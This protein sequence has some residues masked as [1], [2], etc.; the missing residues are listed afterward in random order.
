ME[1]VRDL[2]EVPALPALAVIVN[3]GTPWVTSLAL[4]SVLR[5][6]GYPVLL[7]DCASRDG[8]RA[9][10]RTLALAHDWRFYWLEWPLRRHGATLDALFGQAR[11]ESV[12]L[13]DSD[14]ELL[15]GRAVRAMADALRDEPDAY[16]AGFLQHAQWLGAE[17]GWPPGVGWYAER[18]WIPLVHLATLP[19]RAALAA[20]ASFAQCR[21]FHAWRGHPM[22]GRVLGWRYRLPRATGRR[23]AADAG[24]DDIA[25]AAA[26]V[27]YDTGARLHRHLR[28]R[29]FR[30]AAVDERLWPE[31]RHQHGVS[32]VHLASNARKALRALR[33]LRTDN[34]ALADGAARAARRRLADEYRIGVD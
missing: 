14:V 15:T 17:Q 28:A 19:V 25:G 31:V 16:G 11:A 7:I 29:G 18:M 21:D 2:R 1:A 4:A 12:L 33:I 9:H 30:Y 5:H 6:G 23:F 3:C 27:E 13:V 10:F 24:A 26:F 34:A 8:S 22:L 20:G 32:R